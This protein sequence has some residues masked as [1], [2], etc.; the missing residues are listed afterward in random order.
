MDTSQKA[1][2]PIAVIR[3]EELLKD[4][5]SIV[6]KRTDQ[7][8]LT[9]H[10]FYPENHSEN[11]HRSAIILFHGGLWD[12]SMAT[13]FV[14]QALNFVALGAVGI[15]AEY[16]TSAQH[17]C[18][19]TDAIAD[20][21][22]AILWLRKNNRYLGVDPEKIIAGGSGSG[23]HL[24]LCAAMHKKVENDGFFSG[25]P[26]ALILWSAIVDT[27]KRGVGHDHFTNKRDA[28]RSSPTKN[29]RRKLPPMIFFHGNEDPTVPVASVEKFCQRLTSKRNVARFVP[30]TRA[31]HSFFNF[32]VN[33]NYFVQ[34]LES[35]EGF[36]TD[37]GFLNPS[38][39]SH[40][41]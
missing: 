37:Q 21:Q 32:N 27:T 40:L 23:A 31:T 25:A 29:I 8:E 30:F 10:C 5:E 33:Q 26:N 24:A 17:G 22:T 16:R 13:Q 3:D 34:T 14:P 39:S 28:R 9:L 35:A 36:L 6:Y 20:A 19:P 15:V 18:D 38:D 2:P 11:D 1:V 4:A 7:G 41:S 12:Q